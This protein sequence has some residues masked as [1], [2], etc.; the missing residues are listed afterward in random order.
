MNQF[1]VSL[2]DA[3]LAAAYVRA[4]EIELQALKP[5]NVSIDAP[6][7]D[8]C[9]DDFLVSAKVSAVPLA[10]RGLSLG[11][12]V[13]RTVAATR[14][15]VSCNTNLGIVLLCAPLLHAM[16]EATPERDLRKRLRHVLAAADVNDTEWIYRAI[17][18]ASPGGLGRSREHDVN[19]PPHVPVIAAMQ[20]A[21]YRDRIALQYSTGFADVFEY[22][23]PR[24]NEYRARWNSDTWAAVAVFL[25]LLRRFPDSHIARKYGQARAR[26]VSLTAAALEAE[27][28]AGDAPQALTKRLQAADVEFK[29]VG[30]NPGTT[31]DLTMA[32]LLVLYLERLLARNTGG[33][34]KHGSPDVKGAR[35]ESTKRTHK[36]SRP[37]FVSGTGRAACER[38]PVSHT[39]ECSNE[40]AT[41]GRVPRRGELKRPGSGFAQSRTKEVSLTLHAQGDTGGIDLSASDG[42]GTSPVRLAP[43]NHS[44]L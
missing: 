27:L 17:R 38:R 32:S 30:I 19:D 33:R 24:L 5:G 37:G 12:R 25:G 43:R 11:E 31:A 7:H 34:L 15:A 35:C 21:A 29:I 39:W 42:V 4:C 40:E 8:M 9:A 16:L 14:A 23:V 6:G 10:A 3:A 44:S 18:L 41:R 20:A 13:Y 2:S 1:A 22:A 36:D 28:V 26:E